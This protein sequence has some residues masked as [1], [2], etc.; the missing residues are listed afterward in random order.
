MGSTPIKV[1]ILT[2]DTSKKTGYVNGN[3][4]MS[5]GITNFA[6]LHKNNLPI[7]RKHGFAGN[8]IGDEA[9]SDRYL[10]VSRIKLFDIIFQK[11]YT[12]ILGHDKYEEKEDPN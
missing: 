8:R 11:D 12:Y 7:F 9:A 6:K 3:N 10:H 5:E 2:G 1:Y 4:S